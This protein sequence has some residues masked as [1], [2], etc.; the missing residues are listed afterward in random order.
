MYFMK[1]VIRKIGDFIQRHAFLSFFIALCILFAIILI[2]NKMRVQ[3]VEVLD[4]SVVQ[5][6][7]ETMRVSDRQYTELSG[8]IEKEGV[9]TIIAH[10]PGIVHNI[11]V[12][13]GQVVSVGQKIAYISETYSGGNTAAVGYEIAARQS[14]TQDETFDKKIGIIDDQRDDVRKTN[15]L[16]ATIARKQYTIQKRN[17]ELEFDIT[18][19]QQKQAAIGA[20][21]YAPVS[22]F[23]GVVDRVFVSRG[24]TVNVGERIAVVNANDQ[25]MRLAVNISSSL[26][27]VVDVLQP[28][29]IS[30]DGQEIEILPQ[31]ISR[32]VADDQSY[33]VTYNVDQKYAELFTNNEYVGVSMPIEAQPSVDEV[34]I[35]LDAVRLMNDG[36]IVFVVE[37]G[38]ARAKN[39]VSGEVVG[40]FI[41]V[42]GDISSD[43][44][45]ILNRNVFDGDQVV[46]AKE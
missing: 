35:P 26:A 25:S 6:T 40:G 44:D 4:Q 2:G 43:D 29:I 46:V 21:R 10:V 38:I 15:D 13:G 39:V 36:T 28:S 23:N 14:Q 41:F 27:S 18:K 9:I 45:I 1:K 17:T 42:E 5:K 30:V 3:D 22:P 31:N 34:L 33:V 12:V 7:V 37:D 32:G 11:Y 8:K 16:E 20:A 24:D 19:L